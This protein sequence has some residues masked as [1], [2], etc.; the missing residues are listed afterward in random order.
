MSV[1]RTLVS[2]GSAVAADRSATTP[3]STKGRSRR[4]NSSSRS[5][6]T[7]I[8][9]AACSTSTG[10]NSSGAVTASSSP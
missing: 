9:T 7:Q 3:G 1:S 4:P 5:A 6:S 10:Q 8:V 2:Q